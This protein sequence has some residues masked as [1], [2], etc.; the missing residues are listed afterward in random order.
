MVYSRLQVKFAQI[1]QYNA[2]FSVNYFAQ[3]IA[4]V[5]LNC[6]NDFSKSGLTH[7]MCNNFENQV[8]VE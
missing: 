7:K 1:R 4:K 8:K 5:T 3:I 2:C 6:E